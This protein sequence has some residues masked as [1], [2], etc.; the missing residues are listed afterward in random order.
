MNMALFIRLGYSAFTLILDN[1]ALEKVASILNEWKKVAIL[2]GA[3]TADASAEVIEVAELLGVGIAKA[4]LGKAVLPDDLPFVTGSI[5]LLG[6]KPSW[7][8]MNDCDTLLMV[9]SGLPY[10][11]FL[12]TEGKVKA[13]QIDIDGKC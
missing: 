13:I 2:I 3:G 9:G 5:G 10:S 6:T 1:H 4:L 11:E 7:D 12:R 8:L